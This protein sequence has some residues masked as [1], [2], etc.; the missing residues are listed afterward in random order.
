MEEYFSTLADNFI[1]S[2]PN[3]LAAILIV[4]ISYYVG[5]LLGKFFHRTLVRQNAEPGV[6]HLLSR[7]IKWTI[8]FLGIITALQRFFDVTAFLTGLGIIGFTIGF[9]LQ[10][11]MQ[12]FVSGDRKSV[13]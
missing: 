6:T 13:V 10:N 3:I 1:N 8:I 2:V 4:V 12:N 7:T 9:A 11:I 5:V